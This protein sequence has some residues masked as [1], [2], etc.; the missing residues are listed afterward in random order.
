MVQSYPQ[1]QSPVNLIDELN[2]FLMK[3]VLPL[4]NVD[5]TPVSYQI[6]N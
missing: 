6:E 5:Y 4:K 2:I 3:L 1:D